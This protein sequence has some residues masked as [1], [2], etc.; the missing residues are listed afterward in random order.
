MRNKKYRSWSFVIRNW[1]EDN[2]ESLKEIDC[3]YLCYQEQL[4]HLEI[5]GYIVFNGARWY[6][7]V[8]K[9]MAYAAVLPVA[10]AS[11]SI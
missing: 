2:V 3:K 1:T 4:I 10:I 11:L 5:K 7:G 6:G 8:S 9:L